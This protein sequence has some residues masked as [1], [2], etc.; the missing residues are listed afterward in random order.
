MGAVKR[1]LPE[2]RCDWCGVAVDGD[3]VGMCDDCEERNRAPEPAPE[4]LTLAALAARLA[5]VE[6][7]LAEARRQV[8]DLRGQTADLK[9]YVAY[10]SV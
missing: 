10:N 9:G 5:A 4:P 6:R 3:D 1:A 2:G 7:D 8:A